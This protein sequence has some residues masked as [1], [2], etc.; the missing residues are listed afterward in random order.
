MCRRVGTVLV[1]T[2]IESIVPDAALN[3]GI[4][5]RPSPTDGFTRYEL[6]YDPGIPGVARVPITT[7]ALPNG[8]ATE[9]VEAVLW[10]LAAAVSRALG[11]TRRP[12]L[13]L[14]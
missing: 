12:R 5:R 4:S 2:Y 1:G 10:E 8:A 13:K 6:L 3:F 14:I 7:V 9:E 11:A